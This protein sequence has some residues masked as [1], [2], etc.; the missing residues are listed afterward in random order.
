MAKEM[1][2]SLI[3]ISVDKDRNLWLKRLP[4]YSNLEIPNYRLT[5]SNKQKLV[6]YYEFSGYPR[7]FFID[8]DRRILSF[9]LDRTDSAKFTRSFLTILS[10]INPS[11]SNPNIPTL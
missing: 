2:V 6:D 4:E 10:A 5:E 9:G 7:T 8:A 1:G 3:A 11:N